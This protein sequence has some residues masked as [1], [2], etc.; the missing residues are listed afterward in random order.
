[1]P[2]TDRPGGPQPDQAGE[3]QAIGGD[4]SAPRDTR[5]HAARLLNQADRLMELARDLRREA[6]RL[7]ASLELPVHAPTGNKGRGD[8]VRREPSRRPKQRPPARGRRF[9]PSGERS[10]AARPEARREPDDLEISDGARLMITN[11][12]AG[13]SSREQ[14]I[15]VMRDELGLDN[16]DS[17]L[18]RL[19]L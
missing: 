18:E 7:N 10:G 19:S 9:A 17:I 2:D 13:G 16:P 5:K 11:M 15:G 6:R 4:P 8:G 12:A 1:M 3:A 14:I